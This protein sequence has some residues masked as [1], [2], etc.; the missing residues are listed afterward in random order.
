MINNIKNNK[1]N[2][3][4]IVFMLIVLIYVILVC[5]VYCAK[6]NIRKDY[7]LEQEIISVTTDIRD[8]NQ[9]NFFNR[10]SNGNFQVSKEFSEEFS[11]GAEINSYSIPF[12]SNWE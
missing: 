11:I 1:M 12:Y 7:V 2:Y 8:I 10:V 3:I 9:R 5:V 6:N 4:I